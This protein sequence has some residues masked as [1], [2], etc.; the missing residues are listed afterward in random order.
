VCDAASEIAWEWCVRAPGHNSARVASDLTEIWTLSVPVT[1]P[2]VCTFAHTL[3][4]VSKLSVHPQ[5]HGTEPHSA[6]D[7]DIFLK[8]RKSGCNLHSLLRLL[9]V[10]L[11]TLRH[12]PHQ[13]YWN[14]HKIVVEGSRWYAGNWRVWGRVFVSPLA[15]AGPV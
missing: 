9:T 4:L 11:N 15:A 13:N 3:D 14:E 8:Y 2:E 7:V 5:S 1:W 6:G 10:T 12:F